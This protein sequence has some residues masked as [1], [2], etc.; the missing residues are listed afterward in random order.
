MHATLPTERVHKQATEGRNNLKTKLTHD[1]ENEQVVYQL[2][3]RTHGVLLALVVDQGVEVEQQQEGEV[4][5]AVD[6][7]LDEGRVDD[8]AHA[9]ARHQQ[10]ADG[11]QRPE[12]GHA[13][14]GG[15]LQAG[16]LPSVAGRLA[17][18]HGVE[19]LL[20]VGLSHKLDGEVKGEMTVSVNIGRELIYED[21]KLQNHQQI[22][23]AIAGLVAAPTTRRFG[24]V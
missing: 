16:V 7:E 9:G 20:A 24:P 6:D 18:P 3:R 21:M 17:E 22:A 14:H 8:L 19:E 5:G 11:E 1:P 4:G 13:Q 23:V 15:D 2:R 10:V 12:E